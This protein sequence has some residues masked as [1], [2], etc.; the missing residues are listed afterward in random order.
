[1]QVVHADNWAQREEWLGKAYE[2]I[3]KM[4]NDLK[5]TKPIRAR[6][7]EFEGRPY[8]VLYAY[9]V[10]KRFKPLLSPYFLSRKFDLGS[11]DQFIGHSKISRENYVYHEFKPI[12]GRSKE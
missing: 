8:K 5:L 3:I 12:L 4:H 1:M 9:E 2:I 6:V 10:V 7:R 11:V